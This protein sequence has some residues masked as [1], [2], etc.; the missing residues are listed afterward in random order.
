MDTA[1]YEV[2][3]F[4]TSVLDLNINSIKVYPNPSTGVFNITFTSESIQD[5]K[6]RVTSLL[7]ENI[8][9]VD[10]KQFVGEYT[11]KINLKDNSKGTYFLKIE[12]DDGVINT[13]LILQ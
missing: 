12:T 4:P 6:V 2:T 13:K 1:Y 3:S 8:V 10:L 11:K 9:L 5:L 7:G